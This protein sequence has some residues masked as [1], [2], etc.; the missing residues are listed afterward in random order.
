MVEGKETPCKQTQETSPFSIVTSSSYS[1]HP[2]LTCHHEVSAQ[3]S[4]KRFPPFLP[5]T[6]PSG[7][8]F[9]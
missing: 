1:N 6:T 3:K 7:A 9:L 5:G 8:A 4:R 2:P